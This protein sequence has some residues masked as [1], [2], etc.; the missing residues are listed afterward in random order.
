MGHLPPLTTSHPCPRLQHRKQAH[1][2]AAPYHSV[3]LGMYLGR[4]RCR[5]GVI[6]VPQH[7]LGPRRI[8]ASRYLLGGAHGERGLDMPGRSLGA[9]LMHRGSRCNPSRPRTQA[10]LEVMSKKSTNEPTSS[11]AN[12]DTCSEDRL[13]VI[14]GGWWRV[15]RL[16]FAHL[17]ECHNPAFILPD[18]GPWKNVHSLDSFLVC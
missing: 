16:G 15:Q 7:D 14:R 11:L 12:V 4:D 17:V 18:A 8:K 10:H 9:E 3:V 5:M 2:H 13:F 1:A 6:C